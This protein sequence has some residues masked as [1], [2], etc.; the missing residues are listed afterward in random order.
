VN[1]SDVAIRLLKHQ[2]FHGDRTMKW[3]VVRYRTKPDRADENQ[4]LSEG[5][6]R[7]LAQRTP[8]GLSYIVLRLADGTFMHMAAVSEGAQSLTALPSFQDFRRGI[9]ERS[10]EQ[11][12][13]IGAS[14]VGIYGR[15]A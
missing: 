2:G 3:T 13:A 10:L 12:V 7:E 9:A 14:L 1:P 8:E 15:P 11:P 6:F 4:R 5:V